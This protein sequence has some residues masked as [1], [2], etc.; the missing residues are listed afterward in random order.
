MKAK[1]FWTRFLTSQLPVLLLLVFFLVVSRMRLVQRLAAVIMVMVEALLTSELLQVRYEPF[2]A[3]KE[4]LVLTEV[5]KR[6]LV[7]WDRIKSLRQVVVSPMDEKGE[8]RYPLKMLLVKTDVKLPHM[9][10]AA[11]WRKHGPG[12]RFADNEQVMAYASWVEKE[13]EG[14]KVI[15]FHA[16]RSPQLAHEEVEGGM[17]FMDD[18]EESVLRGINKYSKEHGEEAFDVKDYS[19]PSFFKGKHRKQNYDP[20]EVWYDVL[21]PL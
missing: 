11:W 13:I 8:P 16:R 7:P 20:E 10:A 1:K 3:T 17:L 15:W 2:T 21:H 12:R 9:Q 18:Y 14:W 5:F 4:G 19:Y 6:R